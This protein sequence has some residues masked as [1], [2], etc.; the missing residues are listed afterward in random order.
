MIDIEE[1]KNCLD[2]DISY[3]KNYTTVESDYKQM[4]DEREHYRLM[5][6]MSYKY[7]NETL[8]DIGSYRGLSAIAIAANP[9]NKVISYDIVDYLRVVK[10]D[11]IEY[12]IGDCYKDPGLLK[13]PLILLD[14]DP[15]EGSFE[16]NFVTYLLENSYK[17]IVVFD[18][19][20]LNPPMRDFWSWFSGVEKHDITKYGHHSGTGL[21]VF[22]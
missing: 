17:G 5:A 4:T 10:M 11:N 20:N 16:K 3:A 19:I 13:S 7:N 22:K 9:N 15:H 1:L 21:A 14:V 12:K 6:Y 8:Y 2:F 18:D